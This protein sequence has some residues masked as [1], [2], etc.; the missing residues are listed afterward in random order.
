MSVSQQRLQ[1]SKT[2][3]EQDRTKYPA[4]RFDYSLVNFTGMSKDVTIICNHNANHKDPKPFNCTPT[5]HLEDDSGGGCS[6]CTPS[7][8]THRAQFVSDA[9][10]V[11]REKYKYEDVIYTSMTT[12]V[13]IKCPEHNLTFSM[14][15]KEHKEG[16]KCPK[17]QFDIDSKE[18]TKASIC[19]YKKTNDYTD[20]IFEDWDI[21]VTVKCI[22]HE[23]V[24]E[25]TPREH[26]NK[27]ACPE[28]SRPNNGL[29]SVFDADNDEEK[30]R[31][32]EE[33]QI[34]CT[35]TKS[36]IMKASE[37]HKGK[38]NY[39]YT[40]YVQSHRLVEINCSEHG[41][42]L[43][44]PSRHLSG[45]GCSL[46][47][48]GGNEG[49]LWKILQKYHKN[50]I[51]QYRPKWSCS[52]ETKCK[53]PFDFYLPD[54]ALIVE[55]DGEEHIS[56]YLKGDLVTLE[57]R[58]KTDVLKMQKAVENNISVVRFLI[59]DMLLNRN[60]ACK[61]LLDSIKKYE[62]PTIIYIDP[63]GTEYNN[64]RDLFNGKFVEYAQRMDDI[65]LAD[66]EC[67]LY[68]YDQMCKEEANSN[69]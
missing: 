63:L 16:G 45:I 19:K 35:D 13:N 31:E 55:L 57:K 69:Q 59:K 64:H 2:Q 25:Q 54:L 30:K 5:K 67:F 29:L 62:T 65:R 37:V 20:T 14:T 12:S 4:G 39:H 33:N 58:Q 34:R 51:H 53:L 22:V 27:S 3:W 11:H 42:F 52:D 18:F 49:I 1:K 66:P 48:Y 60:K 28:C 21:N 44:F 61:Q 6:F 8:L 7:K 17:C 24:F 46:C 38:Y 40:E 26:M 50:I 56:P 68:I 9:N 41:D 36:F 23:N 43:A 47:R 15:P 10:I 32:K